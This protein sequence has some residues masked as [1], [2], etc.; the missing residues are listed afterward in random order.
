[1]KNIWTIVALL[2]V[3]T[4]F[5][6]SDFERR[7]YINK[8]YPVTRNTRVEISNKYGSVH[9]N[10]WEKD[11]IKVRVTMTARANKIQNADK[12]INRV[13]FDMDASEGFV[14]L[15][16]LYGDQGELSSI[17]NEIDRLGTKLINNFQKITIDYDVYLPAY[18]NLSLENKYGDVYLPDLEGD[19]MLTLSYG[20]LRARKIK[21]GKDIVLKYVNKAIIDKIEEGELNLRY[22][23]VL[24]DKAGDLTIDSRSSEISIESVNKLSLESAH[25]EIEI[26]EAAEVEGQLDFTKCRIDMLTESIDLKSKYS[27]VVIKQVMPTCQ[28]MVLRGDYSDFNLGFDMKTGVRFAFSL[29]LSK[30][31]VVLPSEGVN[32]SSNSGTESARRMT[33]TFGPNSNCSLNVTA[34]ASDVYISRR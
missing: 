1:M 17:I 4:A 19:L 29:E 14:V 34:K 6:Q 33:G 32:I 26:E 16:T 8:S 18:V 12:Q 20:D 23:E 27:D 28:F 15:K 9:L 7:K 22:S 13:R 10:T 30:S 25:D 24:L 2:I 3:G 5:G 21:S 31:D 11:S